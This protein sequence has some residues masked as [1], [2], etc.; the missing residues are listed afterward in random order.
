[1]RNRVNKAALVLALA[2]ASSDF[3]EFS[4]A[5]R[6]VT[7]VD[8]G[9]VP[10]D[11]TFDN[12]PVL[13][14]A[15]REGRVTEPIVCPAGSWHFLSPAD[16][17]N[18]EAI[19]FVG[20]GAGQWLGSDAAYARRKSAACRFVGPRIFQL[21]GVGAEFDGINFHNGY[22]T[23]EP[24]WKADYDPNRAEPRSCAIEWGWVDTGP[25]SGKGWFSHCTFAGYEWA[26]WLR[27]SN[28]CDVIGGDW[29]SVQHCA[30]FLRCDEPQA[31]EFD[32]QQVHVVGYSRVVFDMPAGGMVRVGTLGLMNR[33]L[34][35]RTGSATGGVNTC[36]FRF[37]HVKIDNN[38]HG[39]RL[40]EC[41]GPIDLYAR[42]L[43]GKQAEPGPKPIVLR[44]TPPR[45][46]PAWQTLDVKLW[47]NGKFWPEDDAPR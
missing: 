21:H 43:I 4:R 2:L 10:N 14:A 25:P 46:Q 44:G 36:S 34:I 6:G 27:K 33:G 42:G 31:N 13:S 26:L 9:C 16:L 12:G 3:G 1:M 5:A 32:F 17:G 39:W 37:E 29:V 30:S 11:P 8:L 41:D 35:L 47:H 20:S 19:R 45:G 15:V 23:T 24:S 18:A 22:Y 40:V 7:L 38:A 28:H